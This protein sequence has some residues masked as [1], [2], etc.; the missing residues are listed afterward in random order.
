VLFVEKLAHQLI[1]TI[2]VLEKNALPSGWMGVG[3]DFTPYDTIH[4]IKPTLSH[5]RSS[6]KHQTIHKIFPIP[7]AQK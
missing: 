3:S 6:R 2:V 7:K 1:P 4:T 5:K